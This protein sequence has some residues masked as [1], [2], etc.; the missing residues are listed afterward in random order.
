VSTTHYPARGAGHPCRRGARAHIATLVPEAVGGAPCAARVCVRIE[1][2]DGGELSR[3]TRTI[4]RTLDE[5]TRYRSGFFHAVPRD[6]EPVGSC[7][8]TRGMRPMRKSI[9]WIAGLSL[10][11]ACSTLSGFEPFQES[12]PYDDAGEAGVR[13]SLVEASVVETGVGVE[14]AAV[15][16]PDAF[17]DAQGADVFVFTD[18]E[19]GGPV[20]DVVTVGQDV[21]EADA[22]SQVVTAVTC[23]GLEPNLCGTSCVDF[24]TDPGHCGGCDTVCPSG[25]MCN[26]GVCA[27]PSSERNTCGNTCVDIQ[28]DHANC[29]GCGNACP[30]GDSCHSGV[31]SPC[32]SAYA[33]DKTCS[34]VCIDPTSDAKNCGG[35]GNV[36][37]SGA[38]CKD[39]TCACPSGD[40]VCDMTCVDTSTDRNNCGGCGS[41]CKLTNA[42]PACSGKACVVSSCFNGY[43]NCDKINSNGCESNPQTDVNNCGACEHACTDGRSCS[44]GV[45]VCPSGTHACSGVCVSDTSVDPATCGVTCA[46]CPAPV[47]GLASCTNE[48]CGKV[49]ASGLTLCGDACVNTDS[50]VGNCGECGS[51]CASG[52]SCVSGVCVAPYM[53][54]GVDAGSDVVDSGVAD[55]AQPDASISE[56]GSS[57]E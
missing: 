15:P 17:V 7:D 33:T 38:P 30:S 6:G 10:C 21:V 55:D 31:C 16:V 26:A 20:V 29:G 13:M 24:I 53:D 47:D 27:C 28:S 43:N 37:P 49:C 45:C 1:P 34:G 11:S 39:S 52:D 36:C 19:A 12:V 22:P 8:C 18:A 48:V 4:I 51:A 44:G 3:G 35:C 57:S 14:A 56:D 2:T 40:S 50:S 9:A 42:N 5:H 54:A 41:V 23:A 46:V 25:E 32:G